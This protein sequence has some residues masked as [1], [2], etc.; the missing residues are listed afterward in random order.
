MFVNYKNFIEYCMVE[1][2]CRTTFPMFIFQDNNAKKI[3]LKRFILI[4]LNC[5]HFLPSHMNW[6]TIDLNHTKG[7]ESVDT[8]E[9]DCSVAHIVY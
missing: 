4:I 8:S 9:L 5:E 1:Q 7:L 2:L 6:L 3:I